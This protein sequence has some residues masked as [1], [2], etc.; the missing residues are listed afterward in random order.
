MNRGD[1]RNSCTEASH[2]AGDLSSFSANLRVP[3]S[4]GLGAEMKLL[5]YPSAS[6]SVA[7]EPI[8][9][10]FVLPMFTRMPVRNIV[11]T[12]FERP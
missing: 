12:M 8:T 9:R 1:T 11:R 6:G 2:R 4:A 10:S 7:P 5:G 3:S